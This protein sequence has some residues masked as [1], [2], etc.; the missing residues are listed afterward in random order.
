MNRLLAY[1]AIFVV[2]AQVRHLWSETSNKFQN[3]KIY[4]QNSLCVPVPV[5]E[6]PVNEP[7]LRGLIGSIL[8]ALFEPNAHGGNLINSLLAGINPTNNPNEITIDSNLEVESP[9][10]TDRPDEQM[11]DVLDS[12]VDQMILDQPVGTT[13]TVENIDER[14]S[15]D[16]IDGDVAGAPLYLVILPWE[17]DVTRMN[18]RIFWTE[19]VFGFVYWS[20]H[21]IR[22]LWV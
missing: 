14:G 7:E 20:L 19:F 8:S 5:E 4:L 6:E 13:E 18:K 12:L 3:E 10:M 17:R 16:E 9:P 2:F 1:I 11:L 21:K 22:L 15:L